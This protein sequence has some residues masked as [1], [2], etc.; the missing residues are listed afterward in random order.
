M[1]PIK[2]LERQRLKLREAISVPEEII[3][4]SPVEVERVCGKPNCRCT[5]GRKHKGL[6]LSQYIKGKPHMTHIPRNME[7]RVRAGVE[8]YRRLK[9]YINE[10]SAVNLELVKR[11]K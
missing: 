2:A 8:N 9:K 5:E 4:G 10:L 3:K 11:G 6:Y 7:K 1:K